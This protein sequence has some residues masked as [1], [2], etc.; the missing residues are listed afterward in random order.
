VAAA[1]LSY[2]EKEV[3]TLPKC[4]NCGSEKDVREILYGLPESPV[5]ESRYEIG[6]CCVSESDPSLRCISC[7]W[8]GE[9][10]NQVQSYI[11]MDFSN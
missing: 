2:M 4:P 10:K 5:D 8:E 6:G 3:M 1:N 7:G 9:F 11:S